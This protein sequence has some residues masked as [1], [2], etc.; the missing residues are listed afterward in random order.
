MSL[1]WTG[2]SLGANVGPRRRTLESAAAALAGSLELAEWRLSGLYRTEPWGAVDGP[3]FLNCAMVGR[4][5][6]KAR[7]VL[8]RC[9]EA[10]RSAGSAVRKDGGARRLD[11]DMLFMEGV[12]TDDA[13]LTLPHPR[14][15]LR[16]FVLAPLAAIWNRPVPGLGAAP[17]RLLADLQDDCGVW[18]VAPEPLEGHAEWRD[19]V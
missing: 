7:E 16:R 1:R 10:E 12:I 8:D 18:R 3:E 6:L 17:Q 15:H 2:L 13:Q 19:G 14:M 9:R 5:P 11:V 4:T